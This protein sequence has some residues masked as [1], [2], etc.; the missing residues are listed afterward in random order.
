MTPEGGLLNRGV[1]FNIN[2][3]GSGFQVLRTFESF[4]TG[5]SPQGTATLEGTVLYG[6]TLFCGAFSRGVVFAMNTDGT[7]YQVL[8]DFAGGAGDGDYPYFNRLVLCASTLYGMTALGG[9]PD[10]GVV[11][12]V[13]T[14]GTGFQILHEFGGGAGGG[15]YPAGSL[16]QDGTALYSMTWEGGALN[17][18]VLF[19]LD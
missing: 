10:L 18:G 9:A 3:D 5:C 4:S 19:K 6:T 12:S 17:W 1:V 13:G 15:Q 16:A 14:D 11:Y 8:H 2:T 7:G